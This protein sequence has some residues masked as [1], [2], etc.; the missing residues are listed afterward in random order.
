[1][2]VGVLW[3]VIRVTPPFLE[4]VIG[5]ASLNGVVAG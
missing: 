1:M 2:A 3:V 4:V 5:T